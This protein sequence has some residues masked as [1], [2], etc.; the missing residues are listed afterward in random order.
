MLSLT[1]C[2]SLDGL[3][4]LNSFDEGVCE[5][6]ELALIGCG[7]ALT[8]AA[9]FDNSCPGPFYVTEH[10]MQCVLTAKQNNPVHI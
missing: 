10:Q 3:Y 6:M 4:F 2:T 9:F 5:T 7:L 8:L 1:I